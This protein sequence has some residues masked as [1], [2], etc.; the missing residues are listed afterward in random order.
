MFKKSKEYLV[1]T[2]TDN[3]RFVNLDSLEKCGSDGRERAVKEEEIVN[4]RL[5]QLAVEP[6]S[7][8]DEESE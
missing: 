6:F 7:P 2:N 4:Y 3:V 1:T 8:R 5:D